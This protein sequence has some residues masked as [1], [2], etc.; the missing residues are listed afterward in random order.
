M[1]KSFLWLST[2]IV[3][4]YMITG[5]SKTRAQHQDA[6]VHYGAEPKATSSEAYKTVS[7]IQVESSAKNQLTAAQ[8]ATLNKY[9]DSQN[10]LV[11]LQVLVA[12]RH[13]SSAQAYAAS[14]VA[15]KGLASTDSMTRMYALDTLDH[16]NV[17][18]IVPTAKQMLTDRSRYVTTKAHEILKKRGADS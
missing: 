14:D 15:R 5:C 16:L 17:P 9:V 7:N 1:A 10:M 6:L 8:L 3:I 2:L 18:D 12:L 13:A 11:R 4:A